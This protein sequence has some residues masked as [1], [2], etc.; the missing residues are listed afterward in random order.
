MLKALKFTVWY[1]VGAFL[2]ELHSPANASCHLEHKPSSAGILTEC[3]NTAL[4]KWYQSTINALNSQLDTEL[5]SGVRES[6]WIR[7]KN[8]RKPVCI[9]FCA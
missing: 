3:T 1:P 7:V 8:E 5:C 9:I 6:F 4:L 2:I